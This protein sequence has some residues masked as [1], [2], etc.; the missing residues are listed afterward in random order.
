MSTVNPATNN[1]TTKSDLPEDPNIH[2]IDKEKMT[3]IDKMIDT[4]GDGELS[5]E[6][7]QA[8]LKDPEKAAK[9]RESLGLSADATDEEVTAVLKGTP[10][11]TSTSTPA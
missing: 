1:P 11:T 8:A 3:E 5:D 7:I 2:V 10:P 9:I 4:N 6:E